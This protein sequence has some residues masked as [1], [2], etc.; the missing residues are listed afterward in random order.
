VLLTE[1]ENELVPRVVGAAREKRE[2]PFDGDGPGQEN[3]D[4]SA[5]EIDVVRLILDTGIEDKA[6]ESLP[7]TCEGKITSPPLVGELHGPAS[8]EPRKID[9]FVLTP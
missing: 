9:T 2:A 5:H 3:L 1:V 8:R 4:V 6:F 7:K